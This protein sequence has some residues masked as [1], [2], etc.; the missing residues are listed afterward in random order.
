VGVGR[1]LDIPGDIRPILPLERRSGV[2][3]NSTEEQKL[4][5]EVLSSAALLAIS[6]ST[7]ER[8]EC[9]SGPTLNRDQATVAPNIGTSTSGELDSGLCS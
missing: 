4:T 3:Y 7:D 2:Q 5:S 6:P 9:T 8:T 1:E